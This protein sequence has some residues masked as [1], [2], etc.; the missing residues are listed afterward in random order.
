[1]D[2]GFPAVAIAGRKDASSHGFSGDPPVRCGPF[3]TRLSAGIEVRQP[4]LRRFSVPGGNLADV[5]VRG[6]FQPESRGNWAGEKGVKRRHH[7]GARRLYRHAFSAQGRK[8]RVKTRDGQ[9][10]R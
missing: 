6:E 5:R 1:M 4:L 2:A 3:S 10:G 7:L 9:S 8:L